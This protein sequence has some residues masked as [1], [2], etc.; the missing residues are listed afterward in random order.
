MKKLWKCLAAT[1]V[2]VTAAVAVT[3]CSQWD[4]PYESLDETGYTVSVRF[5]AN[6][7]VFAGTPDVY[8]VDVFSPA[9][10]TANASGQVEIP[11]LAPDDAVRKENAFVASKT[12]YF[13]AGWYTERALRVNDA[14]EPLDDFGELTSVSGREQGY[15]YSGRWDFAT[16]RLTV[17]ASATQGSAD[18]ALTLYAAW[19][20][21]FN[22]EFYAPT[23]DGSFTQIGTKQLIEVD[24]PVWDE[25]SGKLKMND[26]PTR[27]DMTFDAAYLDETMTV[28]APATVGGE[29][30][31]EHGIVSNS[32]TIKIY[33]TWLD[34]TWFRI[35]TPKQLADNAR[36]GGHY[37]LEADLDFANT[38]WSSTFAVGEF[39]GSIE[40]NGHV[41]KNVEVLQGDNT[42]ING[43]LFGSIAAG[44]KL[45]NVAFENITYKIV[46]GCRLQ[47]ASYGLLAG[48]VSDGATFTDVTI[49]GHIEF[50]KNAFRPQTYN[51]G[52][53]AGTGTA[54]G[55]GSASITCAAEDPDNNTAI[56]EVDAAT[57]RVTVTFA[58]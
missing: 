52:L 7:G 40:G 32:G 33:T 43:G 51:I 49:S 14:G 48:S 20:P 57:G 2:L 4:T 37:I 58:S 35:Y 36:P 50:G 15:T 17:D 54:V 5:D 31:Y 21:Y 24:V 11:L 18:N 23:A 8:V 53:V 38:I 22:F 45:E 1:A 26:F 13:L 30:D 27:E 25:S 10:Y 42:K 34:G 9:N 44:A 41:I 16:D 55:V 3:G 12:N 28:A 19:I 39:T 47:G 6:G 46:A 29:V 56:V